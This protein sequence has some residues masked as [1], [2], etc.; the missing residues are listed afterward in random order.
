MTFLGMLLLCPIFTFL[1]FKSISC[2][3]DSKGSKIGIFIFIFIT[4]LFVTFSLGREMGYHYVGTLKV[5]VFFNLSVI[6]FINFVKFIIKSKYKKNIIIVFSIIIIFVSVSLLIYKITNEKYLNENVFIINANNIIEE[7]DEYGIEAIEKY[8]KRMIEIN[9]VI[10][11]KG[12]PIDFKPLRDASYIIIG[13]DIDDE[14]KIKCYFDDIIVHDLEIGQEI[15]VRCRFKQYSE[16]RM[17]NFIEFKKGEII[18]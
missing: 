12:F 13:N 6:I 18:Q 2:F 17:R 15:T 14:T 11:D 4:E 1:V 16:Y 8:K 3:L 5:F 9:G 10:I 7:F